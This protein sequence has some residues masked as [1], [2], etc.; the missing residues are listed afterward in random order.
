[1]YGLFDAVRII[2]KK[3]FPVELT[4]HVRHFVGAVTGGIKAADDGPHAGS[5]DATD[6]DVGEA[7]AW[8]GV[9]RSCLRRHCTEEQ[10]RG[11]RQ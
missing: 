2:G 10:S 8:R 11:Q 9:A 4:D 6:G 1:M 7:N 3:V 5:V